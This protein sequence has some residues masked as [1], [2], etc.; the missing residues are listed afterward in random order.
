VCGAGHACLK[1]LFFVCIGVNKEV[2][3]E[4]NSWKSTQGQ[5]KHFKYF[6]YLGL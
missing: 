2:C 1:I 5:E 3:S 4:E 6:K